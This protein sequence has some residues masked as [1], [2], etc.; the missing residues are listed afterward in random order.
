MP[1]SITIPTNEEFKNGTCYTTIGKV[2][3]RGG[4]LTDGGQGVGWVPL[5]NHKVPWQ[6][7]EFGVCK[8]NALHPESVWMMPIN[9]AW[10]QKL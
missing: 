4:V 3:A 2:W 9:N 7:G 1:H 5:W 8:S 10:C 6:G